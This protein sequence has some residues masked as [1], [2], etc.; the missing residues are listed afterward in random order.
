M[1]INANGQTGNKDQVVVDKVIAVIA[2][3]IVLQ[4]EL[5]NA[6]IQYARSGQTIEA[7]SKCVIFEDLMFKK[8]LLNQAE[9]DSVEVSEDQIQSDIARRIEY[10][11]QQIGSEEKLVEFYGKSIPEIKDEFHDLIKEQMLTQQMQGSITAGVDISPKEVKAFFNDI[12]KDSLP[13]I[14]SEV[15]VEHI[16]VDPIISAEEKAL[17]RKKIEDIRTRV[18][19]GEDFGTL[20]FLYSQDPGSA[21]KNG[22]LGFMERGALVKEFAA[23]AFT[24]Q[25]GQVS[26]IFET[27]FGFHIVQLIERRGQQ[28]N[29]RHILIKPQ[30]GQVDLLN[31]KTKLDSIRKQIL[32]VDS[33]RFEAT[34]AQTSD[35][36]STRM[37]GGK[38]INP[39]TGSTTFE[40]D[41]VS[42]VDPSLFFILDKMKPG[43]ISQ[44]VIYQKYDGSQSYRIVKLVSLTEPHRANLE[45]DY[46][47]ITS[48]AK[49]EKE[50]AAIDKWIQNK[51][52]VN[53]IRIDET[54]LD[55]DFQ[56]SWF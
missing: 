51:I 41:E 36:K 14:N 55:C 24:I 8:L 13:F 22:E 34:A 35:D 56:H 11:V 26:E 48:A 33:I 39:Q 27:Q 2:D 29:V 19:K 42:K 10:F 53:Y 20:A 15:V 28:A 38:L 6:I 3:Q 46:L 12:P 52:K 25:P 31:A 37:N 17:T 30:V 49:A 54:L 23:V 45:D 5:E 50:K 21:K 16:V 32:E 7:N 4:S 43:E 44:P 47:K 1:L 40:I 18:L 9:L